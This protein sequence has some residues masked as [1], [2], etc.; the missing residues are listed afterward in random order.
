MLEGLTPPVKE[1]LCPM[2]AKLAEKS[3]ADVAIL[4]GYIDDELWT[5]DALA[6]AV[7]KAGYK[8]SITQL[9]KHRKK[10]CSCA[11]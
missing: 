7:T 6:D 11:R 9:H 4:Q 2:I 8:V 5:L 10:K 1:Q 3:P